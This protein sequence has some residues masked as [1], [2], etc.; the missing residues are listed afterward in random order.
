[1]NVNN[2]NEKKKTKMIVYEVTTKVALLKEIE[3]KTLRRNLVY[4]IDSILVKNP[5]YECFHGENKLKGY[6]LDL[7]YPM[8]KD[9]LY[10]EDKVYSF[11]VRTL[12]KQLAQY[13]SKS[14]VRHTTNDFIGVQS[15]FKTIPC[16]PLKTLYTITPVI[17]KTQEHC[18]WRECLSFEEYE[19]QLKKNLWKKYRNFT[20]KEP[21]ESL[22]IW[23]GIMLKSKWIVPFTYKNIT[24]PGDKFELR[25]SNNKQAQEIAYMALAVGLGDLNSRGASFMGY[26]YNDDI[27]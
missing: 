6:T 26:R 12:D 16:K 10:K 8:E 25:I 22:P 5:E 9:G 2:T 14:F 17:V 21:D 7:L 27:K 24:L 13:L 1:M 18:Y 20:G 19:E 3:I 11:R 23:D 15:S 4:F